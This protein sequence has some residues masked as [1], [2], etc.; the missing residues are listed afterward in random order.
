[1]AMAH[2]RS[3]WCF[4]SFTSRP[5]GRSQSMTR[6]SHVPL[7]S[8]LPSNWKACTG[9]W[10]CRARMGLPLRRSHSLMT[11]LRALL[12]SREASNWWEW[13]SSV[14]PPS[15]CSREPV[16]RSHTRMLRSPQPATI[17]PSGFSNDI[18][19]AYCMSASPTSLSSRQGTAPHPSRGVTSHSWIQDIGSIEVEAHRPPWVCIAEIALPSSALSCVC[20]W[21]VPSTRTRRALT[22]WQGGSWWLMRDSSWRTWFNPAASSSFSWFVSH[23]SSRP[24]SVPATSCPVLESRWMQRTALSGSC[25][26]TQFPACASQYLTV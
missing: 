25:R 13:I 17:T 15:R 20:T 23:S 7:A 5:L 8:L 10:C 24:N 12:A 18:L 22:C 26:Q 21:F 3:L 9:A 19:L 14:C 16:S 4:H 6:P 11:P 2:T 1:M